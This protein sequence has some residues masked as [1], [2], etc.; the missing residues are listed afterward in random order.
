MYHGKYSSK[1]ARS[2]ADAPQP[3]APE[4]PA[5]AERAPRRRVGTGTK[6][7]YGIYFSVI[8]LFF[9]GM[10]FVLQ[11]LNDW[12]ISYEASQPDVKQQQVF[13]EL[14]T[15]PD[16]AQ[17]YVR[18]GETDTTYETKDTYAA[19]MAQK[20]GDTLLSCSETSA[21]LSGNHKYIVKVGDEKVAAF[22]LNCV[23]PDEAISRWE[24]GDVALFFTR[25]HS[26][27][28]RTRPGRTVFV[29][30][31]ALSSQQVVRFT[32]TDAEDYLPEGLHGLRTQDWYLDGLLMPPTVT[33]AD[34]AG[35]PVPL[36]FDEAAGIYTE[37][38]QLPEMQQEDYQVTLEAAQAYCKYMI[39]AISRSELR[40]YFD[41]D[42]QIYRTITGNALWMQGYTS[43]RFSEE[44]IS[45]Y[46][47][48]SDELYSVRVNLTLYV[49]RYDDTVKGYEL[50]ST[51]FFQ[52]GSNGRWLVVDMT[53]VDV[54]Q[55]RAQVRLTFVNGDAVLSSQLV[56]AQSA[57]LTLP[58]VTAPAGQTFAGWY[59]KSVDAEG[60][61]T[62]SLV[63]RPD[64]TGTVQLGGTTLEPMTLHAEF[65]KEGGA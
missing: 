4:S 37:Q 60:E 40:R 53:N 7:F 41:A 6:I 2:A 24:L 35:Q 21:G 22:T 43:Y 10:F 20:V 26:V 12:L 49:T 50:N 47:R 63:F 58:A 56:D 64:E 3:A 42:T 16:W 61:T 46:Y 9:V 52:R 19:Y 55:E 8:L 14:F 62:L 48:Y 59:K 27:R 51:F 45:S 18:A 39:E 15:N 11:A 36:T 23:N 57:T 30:G 33:A 25:N 65:T 1:R 38:L 44:T 29:N 5:P 13:Q 34:D 28:I 17:L 31:V 54:Q 32:Q